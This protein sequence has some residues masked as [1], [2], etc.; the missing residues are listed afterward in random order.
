MSGISLK[1]QRIKAFSSRVFLELNRDPLSYVFALGFPIVM[2]VVMTL[3]NSSIPAEA[4]IKIF[5]LEYLSPAI[6]IFALTFV[7]LFAA[8]L[9]S[10]DRE[11]AFLVRLYTSPMR[12]GEFIVSYIIPTLVLAVLQGI[13][14]FLSAFVIT[15]VSGEAFSAAG[16]MLSILASLPSALLM[17]LL[18]LF[19]G[20]LFNEKAAPG[21]SSVVIS[22]AS[23]LG[24]IWMDVEAMGGVWMKICNALP[25]YHAVK[26]ARMAYSLDFS[27]ILIHIAVVSAYCAALLFADILLFKSKRTK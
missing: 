8:L 2:L 25:F 23:I 22:A 21:M 18:G 5:S 17:I 3:V 9:L 24:G 15:L 6:Y 14:T 1:F 27:G 13:I 12:D 10:K 16:A 11:E 7:M 20:C 19:F 26:A 4:G